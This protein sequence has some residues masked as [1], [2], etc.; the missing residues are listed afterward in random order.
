MP[1]MGG[2]ASKA[3][4]W[5]RRS[6][7]KPPPGKVAPED[8]ASDEAVEVAATAGS[9]RTELV[10]AEVETKR[11]QA[12]ASVVSSVDRAPQPRIAFVGLGSEDGTTEKS[13]DARLRFVAD[14]SSQDAVIEICPPAPEFQPVIEDDCEV[15]EDDGSSADGDVDLL[16][17]HANSEKWSRR[18]K[19]ARDARPQSAMST[20][21]LT[22][23]LSTTSTASSG[24]RVVD[25]R[26][27]T[28]RNLCHLYRMCEEYL[29]TGRWQVQPSQHI[30]GIDYVLGRKQVRPDAKGK[31]TSKDFSAWTTQKSQANQMK[32][33]PSST[34]KGPEQEQAEDIFAD[35]DFFKALDISAPGFIADL[36]AVSYFTSE[37]PGQ[38]IVRQGDPTGNV[39][40]LVNGQVGIHILAKKLIAEVNSPRPHEFEASLRTLTDARI[41]AASGPVPKRYT[42]ARK[43]V[44]ASDSGAGKPDSPVARS[45]RASTSRVSLSPPMRGSTSR[46]STSPLSPSS[47]KSATAFMSQGPRRPSNAGASEGGDMSRRGSE[48]AEAGAPQIPRRPSDASAS[49]VGSEQ[50]SEEATRR[51]SLGARPVDDDEQT[52]FATS[53]GFSTFCRAS[54][55]GKQVKALGPGVVLGERG[56][57]N[58]GPR[59]ATV[60][61][62]CDCDLLVVDAKDYKGVMKVILRK[63][64]FFDKHLPGCIDMTDAERN[65]SLH[66]SCRFREGTFIRG[67]RFLS[68]GFIGRPVVYVIKS[69]VVEFTRCEEPSE[70]TASLVS[71]NCP[72]RVNA[73]HTQQHATLSYDV[74][75][76]G[77]VFCSLGA[78]PIQAF[79]PLSAVV[80]S[81]ECTVYFADGD[82]LEKIPASV[83][84]TAR[85]HFMQGL[86]ERLARLRERVPEAFM[87]PIRDGS[88]MF[89]DELKKHRREAL[90]AKKKIFESVLQSTGRELTPLEKADLML[91]IENKV[92]KNQMPASP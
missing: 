78:F 43:S 60:K 2:V 75:S 38:I 46:G 18:Q 33:G 41:W 66:P 24:M 69:G 12:T 84:K 37:G 40:V 45:M 36:A 85:T 68:E 76:E 23:A 6:R 53:E 35:C 79:E 5:R 63:I 47:P 31:G 65:G 83:L 29:A 32:F 13:A 49:D 16:D 15:F 77:D 28:D 7:K 64:R 72:D 70:D 26:R 56:A 4:F 59:T 67:H 50:P 17:E 86:I 82:M 48:S 71:R 80:K 73:W 39:Y 92:A 21:S 54:N 11:S 30:R 14:A 87:P 58:D 34:R 57:E 62:L 81:S 55:I 8:A 20:L 22:S 91:K 25:W 51:A 52:R 10:Q 1:L 3:A 42:A 19:K 74:L 44:K 27:S 88:S 90:K 61:C 89:L 9:R